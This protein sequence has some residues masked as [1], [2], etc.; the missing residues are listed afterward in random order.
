MC[1]GQPVTGLKRLKI[2]V[3]DG[4]FV[5]GNLKFSVR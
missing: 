1:V 5:G 3:V 4:H 2:N